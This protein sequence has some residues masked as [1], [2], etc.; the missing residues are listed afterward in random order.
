MSIQ[1]SFTVRRPIGPLGAYRL[2]W[3]FVKRSADPNVE[4]Q[5]TPMFG[6]TLVDFNEFL[7]EPI[8]D[9]RPLIV[10][11]AMGD[12]QHPDLST[13]PTAPTRGIPDWHRWQPRPRL[14][15]SQQLRQEE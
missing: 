15:G 1:P 14:A 6:E 7:R 4:G 9:H 5:L 3:I 13:S 8:S 2:D 11:L 12:W 10:D